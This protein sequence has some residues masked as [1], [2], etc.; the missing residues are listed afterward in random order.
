[1][2]SLRGRSTPILALGLLLAAVAVGVGYSRRASF[3]ERLRLE[4]ATGAIPLFTAAP[5]VQ[6]F[7]RKGETV[8]LES[9]RGRM[10]LVNFWATW[11]GPCVAEMPSMIALHSQLDPADIAF[12]SIAEDDSWPPVDGYLRRSPLPFDLYRDQ[13]PR[14][15][16]LFDTTSYPTTFLIDRDGQ[17]LYRFSGGRDWSDPVIREL[18]ALDGVGLRPG[19]TR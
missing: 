17:A 3:Q 19:A 7:N 15:E 6:L 18:L 11:C 2:L 16:I 10:V 13:P 1:M 14:V 12:V 4:A 5:S 8:A 9:Y